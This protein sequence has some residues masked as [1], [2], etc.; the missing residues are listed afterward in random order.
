MKT[1]V[2]WDVTS[3]GTTVLQDLLLT[4][5]RALMMEGS[6]FVTSWQ[7]MWHRSPKENELSK[8]AHIWQHFP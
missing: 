1:N 7:T 6:R 3:D 2:F 4:V 5:S 8:H